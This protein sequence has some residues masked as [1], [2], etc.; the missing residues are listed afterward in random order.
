MSNGKLVIVVGG[1]F[2]SEAK[3]HVAAQLAARYDA[4][5]AIR[6]GGPN[7]G[8]T[9]YSPLTGDGLKFDERQQFKLRQ[10]P[11]AS[12]SNP[13][14]T[15][16]I[17]AGALVDPD[18]LWEELRATGRGRV[19]V[20]PAVT[21]LER[22][23]RIA[24]EQDPEMQWGSTKEGIGAA[25]ADRIHRTAATAASFWPEVVG[26]RDDTGELVQ[27]D[28][29]EVARN[30]LGFGGTVLIEAAQGYGLG[31]HTPYYPK[32]TSADCRAIDALADVGLSP[33]CDEVR[34][35]QLEVWVVVRPYPIRVAGESGPLMG[36]T[37]WDELG[38]PEER[39]TVTNKVRR[40]GVWDHALVRDAIR[41]NGGGRTMHVGD[42]APVKV[43]LTMVDQVLP[44]LVEL[45]SLADPRLQNPDVVARLWRWMQRVDACGA[46]VGMLTTSPTTAVF[47][48]DSASFQRFCAG[49][50]AAAG[51]E[52]DGT[53]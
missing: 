5:L 21:I 17:A 22:K 9:V 52:S 11:T 47:D 49:A 3:G 27:S 39:T 40:V 25:R 48:T 14:T 16:A 23:H 34:F 37:S 35:A 42:T 50:F 31:L 53:Y 30:T 45:S 8:H 4:D 41:A 2:G 7:A 38:L 29:A 26:P 18:L 20:D 44:E 13:R 15:I 51:G 43:A 6:T 10:L 1:Q 12:V 19:L 36:E 32:T 33:W 28:V 24:E 46:P